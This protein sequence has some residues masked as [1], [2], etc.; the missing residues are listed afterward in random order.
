MDDASRRRSFHFGLAA[1]GLIAASSAL[2]GPARAAN[3][4]DG[5]WDVSITTIAGPCDP[6]YSVAVQVSDGRLN[7]ANGALLGLVSANGAVSVQMGGGER[8]GTA[9]GRLK[10]N[11]GSGRWS[12][13]ASGSSCHGRWT[14]SRG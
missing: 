14:A 1:L 5:Y 11:V 8:R 4:Y 9:S 6:T 12:G 7:G 10:G 2:S 13:T 3:L